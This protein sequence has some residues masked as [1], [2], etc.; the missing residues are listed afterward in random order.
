MFLGFEFEGSDDVWK[1]SAKSHLKSERSCMKLTAALIQQSLLTFRIL[2]RKIHENIL[3]S[4][5]DIS[6]LPWRLLKPLTSERL[7]LNL[8]QHKSTMACNS[9]VSC[10][11]TFSR[12]NVKLKRWLESLEYHCLNIFSVA[13]NSP[14]TLCESAEHR[15]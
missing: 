8:L 13:P 15:G 6:P 4:Q 14:S 3:T 2:R 11:S 9:S 7:L 1:P 12:Y 5:T 10:L